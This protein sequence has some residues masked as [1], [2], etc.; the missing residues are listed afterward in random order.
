MGN[1]SFQKMET[2]I[3]ADGA[4]YEKHQIENDQNNIGHSHEI[5]NLID[6]EIEIEWS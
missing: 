1:G 6:N 3:D 5:S 2:F 4:R